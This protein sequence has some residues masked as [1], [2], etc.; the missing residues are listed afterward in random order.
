MTN[1]VKSYLLAVSVAGVLFTVMACGG[2]E[3]PR[4]EPPEEAPRQTQA[5]VEEE[6]LDAIE[7]PELD[8]ALITF[9]AGDAW[10]DRDGDEFLADIG[11]YLQPGEALRVESGY[12]ELQAGDL[13]SVRVRENTSIR[14]DD[15][16]LD[17]EGGSFDLRVVSGSVL[18]KVNRLAGNDSYEVRTE[19]AVMGVRGTEFGI[20]VDEATGTRVAVREG[21]VAVVPPAADPQR[22]RERATR[23]GESAEAVEAAIRRFEEQAPVL[24]PNEETSLTEEDTASAE[25]SVREIEAAITEVEQQ[26][27]RGETVDTATLSQLL[28]TAV[29]QS[30]QRVNS[31]AQ[32]RRRDISQEALTDLQ[33]IDEI[34]V[35]R[36]SARRP[37]GQEEDTPTEPAPT[38]VP[39]RLNVEPADAEI[40]LDG[41]RVGSGR[42]S[43]VFVPGEELSFSMVREGYNEETLALTVDESRGRAYRVSLAER[44]PDS[45]PEPEPEPEPDPVSLAVSAEPADAE[46]FVNGQPAG[47]GSVTESFAPDTE[48]TVRAELDGYD[49]MEETVTVSEGM[50]PVRF[51]LSRSIAGVRVEASPTDAEVR[52]D[53]EVVGSGNVT[54]E[55]PLGETVQIEVS[56]E[57]YRSDEREVTVEGTAEAVRFD[58]EQLLGTLEVAATPADAEILLD[59]AVVGEGAVE[60]T[61][62]A[63]TEVN[64]TI[65]RD[66]Y[67]TVQVPVTIQEG[68]NPLRYEL[69]RD[70]GTIRATATP[71][72]ASIL[73]NGSVAGTGTIEQELPAGQEV[74][75]RAQREGYVSEE[76]T[77]TVSSGTTPLRFSLERQQAQLTI[78]TEPSDAEIR[79]SGTTLGTGRVQRQYP[80]AERITVQA[81]RP[82]FADIQRSVVVAEGGSSLELRLD[83]RPVEATLD[84]AGGTFVRGLVGDGRR[85]FGADRQG[86]LYAADP[87]EGRLWSVETANAGNENAL[88]VVAGSVVAFSGATEMVFVDAASGNVLNRVELSGSGSHLFGRRP[89]AWNGQWLVPSDEELAVR[90]ARGAAADRTIAIPG[91]SKMT[92]A[93]ISGSVV[94]ADQQGQV[95][96]ID[97]ADGSVTRTIAT[98]MS[99]PVALAP[100]GVGSTAFLVGRRGTA[101]AVDVSAGSVVWERELAGGRGSFVDPVVAGQ[102]V[103]FYTEGQIVAL[104]TADGSERYILRDAVGA[105]AVLDGRVYYGTSS[106]ELRQVN[107]ASGEVSARL[108]LEEAP[109]GTPVPV[110]ERVLVPLSDGSVV[111]VH[112]AGL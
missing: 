21:R 78:T 22:L 96:V 110:G 37:E 52:I 106:G 50:E 69:S 15:I 81:S 25:E 56:R 9:V 83:P 18:N 68:S 54:V 107:P 17:P 76:Q 72:Q 4:Q 104:N 3:P 108:S 109:A 97:P 112:P 85:V 61:Y 32:R 36:V 89:V 87:S 27:E 66:D 84:I 103:F 34:R 20:D 77:I 88:P 28:D 100:A 13:G 10:L 82:G 65:R 35:I 91:G 31:D 98:E 42:F 1:R 92:P 29:E 19:T 47:T 67:A 90:T 93:I 39:V 44:A 46:I 7:V 94:I 14:L 16:V 59:G 24:E 101:A 57:G 70:L 43:G 111:V 11:D 80:V 23:T 49:S 86:T 58:L 41:R 53:G 38:L 62:P 30:A 99:Q 45:E 74:T 79:V 75:V 105:P 40:R 48:V 95:L 60:E 5:V 64:V 8:H 12:V 51:E 26:T 73:I 33:Q 71:P 6:E 63:G 102:T 55:R 2:D